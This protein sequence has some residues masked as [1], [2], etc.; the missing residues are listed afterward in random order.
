MITPAESPLVL[1]GWDFR[2]TPIS[3]R[4]RMAFTPDGIRE[5][6][7]HITR[8]GVLSEGVIVST[9]N[10]SEIYGVGTSPDVEEAVTEFVAGSIRAREPFSFGTHAEPAGNRRRDH[11]H[12][13]RIS[14][15]NAMQVGTRDENTNDANV[16]RGSS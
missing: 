8:Q 10:R 5:A 16:A 7:A 3:L 13:I 1:V 14:S 2:R 6:L 15:A 11:R 9:C 4:E 12:T